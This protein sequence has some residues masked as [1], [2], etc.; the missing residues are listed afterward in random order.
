M[1]KARRI[2]A[3]GNRCK[4]CAVR[5]NNVIR[6]ASGGYAVSDEQRAKMSA[7]HKGRPAPW[8][9]G[10]KTPEHRY[11]LHLSHI[12]K[13]SPKK[14]KWTT[15]PEI[16][17]KNETVHDTCSGM[18]RRILKLKNE[19]KVRRTFDQLGYT[20]TDFISR[21]ESQFSDGMS[22]G[23]YGDWQVDHIKP[24]S[25]FVK[26]GT[27]DVAIINALSNLQPLWRRDNLSKGGRYTTN[28]IS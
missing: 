22:W 6:K 19:K 9:S 28:S 1:T 12:G 27:L 2:K 21:I 5:S 20:K 4:P 17:R 24:V 13:P 23:N 8:N 7:A 26:E 3:I 14:G 11:K 18:V 10:P 15:P 16:R 25:A